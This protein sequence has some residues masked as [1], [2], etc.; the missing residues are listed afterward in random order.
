M[1]CYSRNFLLS[2]CMVWKQLAVGL[3]TSRHCWTPIHKAPLDYSTWVTLK[4][5]GLL[6]RQRGCRGGEPLTKKIKTHPIKS[7]ISDRNSDQ[8]NIQN[9]LCSTWSTSTTTK[10]TKRSLIYIQPTQ[11]TKSTTVG[12]F[13]GAVECSLFEWKI[14]H[15][16]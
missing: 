12:S 8:L 1:I 5:L 3:Q 15:P 13:F 10:D 7:H 11:S 6:Q 14:S 16:L 9:S 2:H 4:S